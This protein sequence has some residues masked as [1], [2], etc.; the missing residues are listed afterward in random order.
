MM[1]DARVEGVGCGARETGRGGS[2]DG[3]GLRTTSQTTTAPAPTA[4]SAKAAMRAPSRRFMGA[5]G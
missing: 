3:G 4:S 5:K 1:V 2:A